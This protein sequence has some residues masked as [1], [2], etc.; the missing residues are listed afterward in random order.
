[1]KADTGDKIRIIVQNQPENVVAAK[2]NL[3]LNL[4]NT[5]RDCQAGV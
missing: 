1:M 2:S 3:Y 5:E 4:A